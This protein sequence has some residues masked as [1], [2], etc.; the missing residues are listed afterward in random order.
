MISKCPIHFALYSAKL[1]KDNGIYCFEQY[2]KCDTDNT[3]THLL[4]YNSDSVVVDNDIILYCWINNPDS[5][6]HKIENYI[7]SYM[8]VLRAWKEAMDIHIKNS[9]LVAANYCGAWICGNYYYLL[10]GYYKK[11]FLSNKL[12]KINEELNMNEI[13]EKYHKVDNPNTIKGLDL[14]YNHRFIFICKSRLEKY[15]LWI[16]QLLKKSK[17]FRR[18]IDNQ[19][20]YSDLPM[21]QTK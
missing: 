4:F 19:K 14:Y 1:I 10:I 5:C 20:Y 9:D 13:I 21:I 2:K 18:Y 6:S 11:Y 17:F 12:K 16:V 8:D 7:D 15:K 3:F